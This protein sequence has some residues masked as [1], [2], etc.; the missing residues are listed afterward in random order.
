MGRQ[1]VAPGADG[2]V[3]LALV[4]EDRRLA[5]PDDELGAEFELAGTGFRNPVHQFPAAVVKPLDYL[6]KNQIVS[7][8]KFPRFL[9]L[10]PLFSG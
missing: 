5:F 7:T 9:S 1:G 3:G 6:Q 10:E 4:E 2:V 8:H